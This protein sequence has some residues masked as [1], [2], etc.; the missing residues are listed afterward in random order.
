PAARR[1]RWTRA[2]WPALLVGAIGW[3]LVVRLDLPVWLGVLATLPLL[4]TP[5]L[6]TDRYAGLGHQLSAHHL[7]V[8]QGTFVRRRDVLARD[9]VIGWRVHQSFF[10]RR[11]GLA[12]VLATTAAG[13]QSYTAYDVPLDA[14]VALA[15][16]V[17]PELLAPFLERAKPAGGPDT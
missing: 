17:D 11:V 6:A 2:L 14:G 8:Q 13:K 12:H 7:V 3:G 5:P 4:A 1:R 10:Q 16:A 9:G 15:L